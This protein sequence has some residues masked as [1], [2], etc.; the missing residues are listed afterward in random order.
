[1]MN[2]RK[3][4][5]WTGSAAAGAATFR[6]V[7]ASSALGQTG[8][9]APSDRLV[10][11]S[12]G[13]GTQGTGLLQAFLGHKD[14]QVVAVC[15]VYDSQRQKAKAIVDQRYGNTNCATYND[16]REICARKNIDAV[17]VATPDHWHVLVSLEAARNG[18]DMYTEKA[19]GLGV[20]WDE[21]LQAACHKYG[22]VFQ[23]GT[24][25]R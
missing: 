21:A 19:L 3:F 9:P 5:Q 17:V 4:L 25:Q 16:F 18:K 7:V 10:M 1:M 2:R 11:A 14:A 6:Y 13:L 20:S 22:T 8:R 12:I 24:Q 15:D 23:W